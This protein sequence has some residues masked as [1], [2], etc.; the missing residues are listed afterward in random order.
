MFLKII[1]LLLM[2]IFLLAQ[3]QITHLKHFHYTGG[4]HTQG[5]DAIGRVIVFD[6]YFWAPDHDPIQGYGGLWRI[7]ECGN[8][9]GY[10]D[11]DSNRDGPIINIY[12]GKKYFYTNFI[13]GG[14]VYAPGYVYDHNGAKLVSYNFVKPYEF[15]DFVYSTNG[16]YYDISDIKNIKDMGL[17]SN[18]LDDIVDIQGNAVYSNAHYGKGE[19]LLIQTRTNLYIFTQNSD[20]SLEYQDDIDISS[21]SK[22]FIEDEDKLYIY[23]EQKQE[24]FTYKINNLSFDFLDSGTLPPGRNITS[25]RQFFISHIGGKT[26]AIFLDNRQIIYWYDITNLKNITFRTSLNLGSKSYLNGIWAKDHLLFT[27]EHYGIDIFMLSGESLKQDIYIREENHSTWQEKE[28]KKEIYDRTKD[29]IFYVKIGNHDNKLNIN[30]DDIT[31]ILKADP[32]DENFDISYYID[33]DDITSKITSKDGYSQSSIKFGDDLIIKIVA[34]AKK[35]G[36]YKKIVNFSSKIVPKSRCGTPIGYE[37]VV[38]VKAVLDKKQNYLFKAV[39]DGSCDNIDVNKNWDNKVVTKVASKP[40]SVAVLAKTEDTLEP[41]DN[42]SINALELVDCKNNNILK[43]LYKGDIKTSKNGCVVINN[44]SYEDVTKC[45]NIKVVA[46]KTDQNNN[47]IGTKTSLSDSFTIRPDRFEISMNITLLKAGDEF[48]LNIKAV[49]IDG[50]VVKNYQENIDDLVIEIENNNPNC[51]KVS[52]QKSEKNQRFK[53]GVYQTKAYFTDIGKI[54]IEIKENKKNYYAIVDGTDTTKKDILY[55]KPGKKSDIKIIP[56][57]I[58]LFPSL[59][60]EDDNK[61]TVY[62]TTADDIKNMGAKL[63]LRVQMVN[64]QGDISQNFSSSCHS[65]D[66]NISLSFYVQ[67]AEES[68]LNLFGISNDKVE[69]VIKDFKPTAHLTKNFSQ[70]LSMTISKNNFE[71]GEANKNLNINFEK[72]NNQ[73]INP[74]RFIPIKIVAKLQ[75]SNI[76]TQT[77]IN[78]PIDFLYSRAD[79]PSPIETK[80]LSINTA[81]KELIYSKDEDMKNDLIQQNKIKRSSNDVYWYEKVLP[82][83]DYLQINST[84]ATTLDKYLTVKKIAPAMINITSSKGAIKARIYYIPSYKWLLYDKYDSNVTRHHFDVYIYSSGNWAGEGE[85]G[86][87]IDTEISPIPNKTIDW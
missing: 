65:E 87:T 70:T 86:T 57:S 14:R 26:E 69:F 38:T 33:D 47:E 60:G 49:D 34:R 24:I 27:A 56:Y 23:D 75:D 1:S 83:D 71:N 63:S 13:W 68:L 15:N 10:T 77:S 7:D 74:I 54:S 20:G 19:F 12:I 82:K 11:I 79:V 52:L 73:P 59:Q 80:D 39:G 55:I 61:T 8:N 44:L 25:L 43:T 48:D 84:F 21:N 35:N 4:P 41:A 45:A 40:F 78:A 22:I 37:N 29:A 67:S 31:P 30:H 32:S 6:G 64:K 62:F 17:I 58:K 81:V 51:K 5:P 9:P 16:H 18:E 76:T 50:K 53:N 42:L 36:V 2:P 46:K 66:A 3:Y 28:D 85:L 72:K